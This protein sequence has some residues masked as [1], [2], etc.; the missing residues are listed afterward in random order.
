MHTHNLSIFFYKWRKNGLKLFTIPGIHSSFFLLLGVSD[1]CVDNNCIFLQNDFGKSFVFQ[2][3]QQRISFPCKIMYFPC[4]IC[5]L[6]CFLSSRKSFYL[7]FYPLSL[8]FN[9][10]FYIMVTCTYAHSHYHLSIRWRHMKIIIFYSL[11]RY[12]NLH[13][14]NLYRIFFI[15]FTPHF[16]SVHICGYFTR[17]G[18]FDKAMSRK[19]QP[20]I[21][22]SSMK[23]Y[24]FETH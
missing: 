20:R 3:H 24:I 22:F 15:C 5:P 12:Q 11:P 9:K 4:L 1:W 7:A 21:K 16:P 2:L 8:R 18:I 19:Q 17:Q 14:I 13:I 10:S 23:N 6:Q